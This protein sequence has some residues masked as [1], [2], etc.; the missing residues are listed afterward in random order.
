MLK[1]Y[2]TN[3]DSTGKEVAIVSTVIH[4]PYST[5]VTAAMELFDATDTKQAG[6]LEIVVEPK[7]TICLDTKIFLSDGQKLRFY[8]ADIVISGSEEDVL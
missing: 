7:E 1:S 5:T 8:G 4:N 2:T 3:I 6:I